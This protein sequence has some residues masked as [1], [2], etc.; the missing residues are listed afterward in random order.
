[1]RIFV[2]AA[3]LRVLHADTVFTATF[4][5]MGRATLRSDQFVTVTSTTA[6]FKKPHVIMGMPR[7]GTQS[8]NSGYSVCARV[9]SVVVTAD[10]PTKFSVR[11]VQPNDTWCNYTWWTPVVQPAMTISYMIMDEGHY[12]ISGGEF[13]ISNREFNS[14]CSY[15]FYRHIWF[16]DFSNLAVK[17]CSLATT[18]TIRDYRFVTFREVDSNNNARG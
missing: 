1:M 8:L 15:L 4:M 3:I 2:I 5:E 11:L 18:Q 7:D 6:T 16:N 13:D 14:H 12:V 17:P 9:R 10:G